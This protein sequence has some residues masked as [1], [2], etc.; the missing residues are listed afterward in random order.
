EELESAVH[1]VQA[2]LRES[3]TAAVGPEGSTA[4]PLART[5]LAASPRVSA[6]REPGKAPPNAPPS[7][8][9]LAVAIFW[10]HAIVRAHASRGARVARASDPRSRAAPR[11]LDVGEVRPA[12]LRGAGRKGPRPLPARGLPLR[13]MGL[14]RQGAHH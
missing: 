10:P 12:T 13:R 1:Q 3:R 5:P 7:P 14:P 8:P 9:A 4:R 6:A 2:H 11:R